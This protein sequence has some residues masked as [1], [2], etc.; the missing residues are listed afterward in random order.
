VLSDPE[1]QREWPNHKAFLE[2]LNK[3]PIDFPGVPPGE[4]IIPDY[5]VLDHMTT[6]LSEVVTG[7]KEP[8]LALEELE[9]EYIEIFKKHGMY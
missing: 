4:K 5:E 3:G 9:K 7:L 1:V 8:K 2:I 6:K